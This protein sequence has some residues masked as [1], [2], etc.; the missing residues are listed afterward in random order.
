M[1]DSPRLSQL[2][3]D[4]DTRVLAIRS[5]QPDWPCG[6][7]CDGCC[8]RLARIPQLTREEWQLLQTGIAALPDA[9]REEVGAGIIAL[10]QQQSRPYRCPLIDPQ[11]GACRTYAQRPIACRTYGFYL[12]RGEGLYCKE[13]ETRVDDGRLA[14]VVWGNHDAITQRLANCGPVRSL[15]E[16]FG[17]G[18]K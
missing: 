10:G 8:H 16:W 1:A 18:G 13:I 14:N 4:I 12:E 6:R 11:S 3:E 9:V 15:A 2:H 7:G 5:A 17:D